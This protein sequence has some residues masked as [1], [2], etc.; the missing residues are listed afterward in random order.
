MINLV[1]WIAERELNDRTVLWMMHAAAAAHGT[2]IR[3]L[4]LLSQSRELAASSCALHQRQGR[5]CGDAF[6]QQLGSVFSLQHAEVR[7]ARL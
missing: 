1:A 5:V 4:T 3:A 6:E 2:A 7:E